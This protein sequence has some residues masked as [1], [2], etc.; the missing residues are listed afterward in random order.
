MDDLRQEALKL[1]IMYKNDVEGRIFDIEEQ[2]KEALFEGEAE[3]LDEQIEHWEATLES[4]E[5]FIKNHKEV[6][7]G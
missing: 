2:K 4:I 7:N 5:G 6:E 3:D 1:A